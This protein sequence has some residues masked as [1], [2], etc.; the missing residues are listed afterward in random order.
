MGRRTIL[1][2]TSILIAAVGTALVA[3]YVRTADTRA[4]QDQTLTPV[5]V[6]TAQIPAGT[7]GAQATV[8]VRQVPAALLHGLSLV[9]DRQQIND[10]VAQGLIYAGTPIQASM[11]GTTTP[12]TSVLGL[13]K[14]TVAVTISVSDAG[15]V[16]GFAREGS[17]VA[18]YSTS[19][20][21]DQDQSIHLLLSPVRVITVGGQAPGQNTQQPNSSQSTS[22]NVPQ[23]LVTLQ[24]D[25]DKAPKLILAN[26]TS[27]LYLALLGPSTNP[28]PGSTLKVADLYAS[29]G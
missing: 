25:P 26:E 21:S 28:A 20:A 8:D 17:D 9:T 18:I 13:A 5:L 1:L 6:A 10:K 16:A 29:G 7:N 4:Q 3:V 11:F 22:S 2:I 19:G 24:V 14:D 27:T 15:R 12:S 23:T